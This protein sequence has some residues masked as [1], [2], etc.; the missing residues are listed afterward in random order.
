MQRSLLLLTVL[1]GCSLFQPTPQGQQQREQVAAPVEQVGKVAESSGVPLYAAIGG[2]LVGA[3]ALLR[4]FQ[5]PKPT[6]A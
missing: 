5:K 4:T 2:I 3:A 6:V 1:T